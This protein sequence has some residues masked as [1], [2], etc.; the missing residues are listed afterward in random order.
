MNQLIIA[1]FD[2]NSKFL[3]GLEMFRRKC[4]TRKVHIVVLATISE[5]EIASV[6]DGKVDS[7]SLRCKP[8]KVGYMKGLDVNVAGCDVQNSCHG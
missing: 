6:L 5:F 1:G 2:D 7:M 3:E 4:H 8:I